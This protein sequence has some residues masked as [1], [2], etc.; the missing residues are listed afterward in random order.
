ML[1]SVG[2]YCQVGSSSSNK[3]CVSGYISVL[4][5]L[6]KLFA[7]VRTYCPNTGMTGGNYKI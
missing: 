7:Q 2:S 4:P 3:M 6:H 1:Y 5:Q